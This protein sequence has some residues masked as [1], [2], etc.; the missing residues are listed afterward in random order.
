MSCLSK[1]VIT[2]QWF[3]TVKSEGV[4]LVTYQHF[5][6]SP[7]PMITLVTGAYENALQEW[8][9]GVRIKIKY[10]EEA[11][12]SRYEHHRAALLNVQTKSPTWFAKFQHELYAKIMYVAAHSS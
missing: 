12:A 3:D 2:K 10:T 1:A 7:G 9:T 8:A 4:R 5:V 11:F 6:D